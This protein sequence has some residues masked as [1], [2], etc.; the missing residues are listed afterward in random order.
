MG[1]ALQGAVKCLGPKGIAA[2]EV[3]AEQE[4]THRFGAGRVVLVGVDIPDVVGDPAG[5]AQFTHLGPQALEGKEEDN[6]ER[7]AHGFLNA[8]ESGVVYAGR[9]A[10]L[11]SLQP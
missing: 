2:A 6:E 1:S 10:K 9:G 4:P 7:E 3:V 5:D 8:A 11:G